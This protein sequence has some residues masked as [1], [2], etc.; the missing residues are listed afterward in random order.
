MK[1]SPANGTPVVILLGNYPLDRQQSMLRFADL[2]RGRLERMGYD[3]ETVAPG[4]V[5]GHLAGKGALAKWLGH[6][7]KYILFPF[8]LGGRLLA[9]AHKYPH[10]KIV[11]HV[12]DHSNSVYVRRARRHF[13][14]LV[15]CHDLLAVRGALGEDVHCP[16]SGFG[17]RLQT[18]ILRGLK[19]ATYVACVSRATRNDLIRL[20]G[21]GMA[22][23]S[24]HV[25]LGL[26]Y[27]YRP[28]PRDQAFEKLQQASL[29]TLL[30]GYILHVGSS[31]ERKNR[32]ALLYAVAKI[33]DAWP[34]KIVFA[35]ES[36]TPAERDLASSLGLDDRLIG[37]T[38][39]DNETLL[40]LY[41][42]AH[43]LVFMSWAEGFGWPILEAQAC[44]C[45]VICS[46]RTSV[47]EVAGPG[48]L[49][50]EPEDYA[51]IAEDIQ[52]LNNPSFRNSL[53]AQGTTNAESYTIDRMM[54]AYDAIYRRI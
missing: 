48:A 4:G 9:V 18:A 38:N 1:S 3:V 12:C 13:P 19:K 11:V 7:D 22:D 47:P 10:R 29:E 20:G 37:I 43:A 17:K 36:V 52:R 51:G 46:D 25:P 45:P 35:G 34:G 28:L 42:A 26:N 40:A 23:R 24:E 21:E 30:D 31:H 8:G 39:P 54:S 6:V 14:I 16:V 33:K 44:G 50:R 53:I 15:T 27:P 41:N 49:V 32:P 5:L 2:V